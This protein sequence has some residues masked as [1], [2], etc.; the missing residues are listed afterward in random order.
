M[1][2]ETASLGPQRGLC[3]SSLLSGSFCLCSWQPAFVMVHFSFQEQMASQI[4]NKFTFNTTDVRDLPSTTQGQFLGLQGKP[5]ALVLNCTWW[6]A[7]LTTVVLFHSS[8]HGFSFE[9]QLRV[10]SCCGD[11]TQKHDFFTLL[12]MSLII[13]LF[14]IFLPLFLC[15]A[16]SK[17]NPKG[18]CS[19]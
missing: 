3:S 6:R 12:C 10:F 15:F 1:P 5:L 4:H 18:N 9:M 14:Y 13:A 8:A 11:S 7:R 19:W 17:F 16:R 2:P